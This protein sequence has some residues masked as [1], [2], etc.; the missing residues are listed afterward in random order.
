MR[1]KVRQAPDTKGVS[2]M[3]KPAVPPA[4]AAPFR[5]GGTAV[6]GAGEDITGGARLAGDAISG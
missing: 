3:K 2:G 5:A 1:S 6:T 4:L